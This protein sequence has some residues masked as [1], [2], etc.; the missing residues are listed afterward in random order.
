VHTDEVESLGVRDRSRRTRY[1]KRKVATPDRR[2]GGMRSR[3][4]REQKHGCD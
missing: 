1:T 3:W 4:G 2:I